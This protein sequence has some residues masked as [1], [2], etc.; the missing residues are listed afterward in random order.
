MSENDQSMESPDPMLERLLERTERELRQSRPPLLP[1]EAL[2][3]VRVFSSLR[4]GWSVGEGRYGE[5]DKIDWEKAE[6]FLNSRLGELGLRLGSGQFGQFSELGGYF[7]RAW[8][9]RSADVP[10]SESIRKEVG[11]LDQLSGET[12]RLEAQRLASEGKYELLVAWLLEGKY[13]GIPA[14]VLRHCGH[15]PTAHHLIQMLGSD[16][17]DICSRAAYGLGPLGGDTA[18]ASLC[19]LLPR[20]KD[21][22]LRNIASALGRLGYQGAASALRERLGRV[23]D[24]HSRV[25]LAESLA[26]CGDDEGFQTLV[27]GMFEND[28]TSNEFAGALARLDDPRAVEPMRS[29]L[30]TTKNHNSLSVVRKFLERHE[31]SGERSFARDLGGD[32]SRWRPRPWWKFWG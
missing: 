12:G 31:V 23:S 22:K 24:Y 18:G 21:E 13:E 19:V 20:A 6:D 28:A 14:N 7:G 8:E 4:I 32:A 3:L 1:V 15:E 11:R 26:R 16:H 29:L 10:I 25:I 27:R 2:R 17:A 30:A 9:I 5:G